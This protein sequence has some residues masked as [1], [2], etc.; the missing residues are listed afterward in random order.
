M[1]ELRGLWRTL[2]GEASYFIHVTIFYEDRRSKEEGLKMG[3]G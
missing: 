1:S 3:A 2:H